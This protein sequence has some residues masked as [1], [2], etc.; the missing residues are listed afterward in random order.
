V[1]RAD[2]EALPPRRRSIV[3]GRIGWEILA[4]QGGAHLEDEEQRG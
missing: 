4:F 2:P 1:D 3:G